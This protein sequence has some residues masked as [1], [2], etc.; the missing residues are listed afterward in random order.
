M[1][2]CNWICLQ[3]QKRSKMRH[4]HSI[5]RPRRQDCCPPRMRSKG[6]CPG[7]TKRQSEPLQLEQICF[8]TTTQMTIGS[9]GC[10]QSCK[11]INIEWIACLNTSLQKKCTVLL[12]HLHLKQDIM[13]LALN[14]AHI[15]SDFN[16]V[17]IAAWFMI[18]AISRSR[19][20]LEDIFRIQVDHESL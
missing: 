2:I 12:A 18:G 1:V 6:E 15:K 8:E 17:T 11:W 19:C 14:L 13:I 4:P 5:Q 20:L 7:S 3:N 9:E 10:V 16:D